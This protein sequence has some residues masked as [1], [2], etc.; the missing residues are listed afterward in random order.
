M[1]AQAEN[2][3][4]QEIVD[5][6]FDRINGQRKIL[7][8]GATATVYAA[9]NKNTHEGIAVKELTVSASVSPA[10]EL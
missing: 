2:V 9:I 1:V 4:E 5:W 10:H 3:V 8:Q 7:G 6:E